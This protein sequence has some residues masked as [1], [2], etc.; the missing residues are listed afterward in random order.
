MN[1]LDYHIPVLLDEVL[2][3]MDCQDGAT[4]IDATFGAGGYSRALLNSANC[5]VVAFDRD[6][7]VSRFAERLQ[8]DFGKNFR[9]I[10]KQFSRISEEFNDN[11]I[12]GIVY[13]LGVSSMQLDDKERGFSFDSDVKLDMR[14]DKDSLSI[15]A[16]DVVNDYSEEE[17]S[18]IFREYGD[19]RKA[20][21]IAKKIIAKRVD[22][23]IETCR[24]LADIIRSFYKG[25]HKIDPATKCFQAIRIEVNS[26]LQEIADSLN[27]AVNLLKS[28]GRIV[29]VSFHS[30]EDGL[31][32]SFFKKES[33]DDITY[34]RY[35]P[36]N[37]KSSE[38]YNLKI[39]TKSAIKPNESEVFKN[40]RSRSSRLRAAIK[41]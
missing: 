15:T 36:I 8:K 14:M 25:Y 39:L 24:Q 16:F 23:K 40:P 32:K 38:K 35:E 2:Q 13:D 21:L 29:V 20:K 3:Y 19:E 31:V 33:G 6:N 28:G 9:F 17:L 5:K 37:I 12:D 4:Y 18:R 22:K 10:N 7:T 1:N 27:Q 30:L 11:E 41:I 34:S 26:E